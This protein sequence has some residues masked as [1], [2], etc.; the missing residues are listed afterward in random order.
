LGRTGSNLFC[1]YLSS[2][3]A[4]GHP[5]EYFNAAGR[6]PLGLPDYPDEPD[7]QI[8]CVLTI[9]ATANG[10]YGI[11]LFPAQLDR[12]AQ[13]VRW[14]QRLPN[15]RFVLLERHDLVAQAISW[16]RAEQT[17]RWRATMPMQGAE[18]YDAGRIRDF[19]RLAARDYARWRVFFARNGVTPLVVAYEELTAMP[20][21]CVD[22]VASL[23]GL[24]GKTPIDVRKVDLTIQRDAVSA[25][26]RARFL[27]E[28][29]NLDELDTL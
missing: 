2:T 25:E 6:R 13:S 5:L 29:R 11:K 4:L 14:T 8:E 1:Q 3:G 26:W 21:A 7:E 12:I 20:Q 27:A 23:F 9:G 22:R 28:Q 24:E 17:N 19:L 18:V 15:L 16:L 10:I